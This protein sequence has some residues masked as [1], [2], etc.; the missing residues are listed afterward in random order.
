MLNYSIGGLYLAAPA[1]AVVAASS[2]VGAKNVVVSFA[3][4]TTGLTLRVLAQITRVE[5][6]HDEAKELKIGLQFN[7]LLP[8]LGAG[9]PVVASDTKETVVGPPPSSFSDSLGFVLEDGLCGRATV[10][11]IS[12]TGLN[13]AGT[14]IPVHGSKLK[15]LMEVDGVSFELTGHVC[16][17]DRGSAG[18]F[19]VEVTLDDDPRA[20]KLYH[21]LID[22]AG[23][24]D[25]KKKMK[26]LVRGLP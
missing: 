17:E 22:R 14:L 9:T 10:L 1:E 26:A 13:L 15:L 20:E 11:S 8:S 7:E 6:A 18:N 2:K 12:P 19:S 25:T 4:P 24:I 21:R 5:S 3:H 16:Q 23:Q